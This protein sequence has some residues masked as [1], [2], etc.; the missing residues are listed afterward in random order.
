M[1]NISMLAIILFTLFPFLTIP[2][3]VIGIIKDRKHS[4]IYALLLA[5][6][7]AIIAY[8]FNPI[9]AQDL[10]RYYYLMNVYYSPMSIGEYIGIFF[11]NN[12]LLFTFIVYL[13]SKTGNF[14]IL[15]FIC[16][17]IGYFLTFYMILD[18]SRIKK[19]SSKITIFMILLFLCIYYHINFIS[20]LSQYLAIDIMVFAFYLEYIKNKK[21][22]LYKS[23]YVIPLFIHISLIIVLVVR[24]LM[25]FDFKKIWKFL[26][27]IF[28]LYATSPSIVTALLSIF[29]NNLLLGPLIE[30]ADMYLVNASHIWDSTYGISVLLLVIFFVVIF[31]KYKKLNNDI[32]GEKFN[33]LIE[34][35]LWFNISSV[36]YFDI[37]TRFSNVLIILMIIYI[38]NILNLSKR[39]EKICIVSILIVFSLA[40]ASVS[41]NV[42]RTND[43][44]DVF[45]KPYRNLIYYF[46]K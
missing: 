5:F 7:L 18:Y 42:F 10:Y 16:T 33:N 36:L 26:I 28:A 32:L 38:I 23:L 22:V 3:I 39:K 19:I 21:G 27:P 30:K 34:I 4:I 40:F 44:N 11:Q 43:F 2:I 31:Y 6:L 37:F 12:K 46:I 41:F 8:N 25:H 14:N 20:S 9:Q 13:I 17:L 35:M 45:S 1:I 15:P 24:I 29:K